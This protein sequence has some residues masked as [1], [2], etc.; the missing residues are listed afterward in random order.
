MC[1][2]TP[3]CA[4]DRCAGPHRWPRGGSNVNR[5]SSPARQI[6]AS[7]TLRVCASAMDTNDPRGSHSEP[8]GDRLRANGSRAARRPRPGARPRLAP[9]RPALPRGS[10]RR[11]GGE[12]A[13]RHAREPTR[14][15]RDLTGASRMKGHDV[16]PVGRDQWT[17][18]RVAAAPGQVHL[19]PRVGR[20]P[21]AGL[22]R[23]RGRGRP[24]ARSSAM[25]SSSRWSLGRM[26]LW[27]RRG[28]P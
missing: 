14:N 13:P 5:L 20:Q 26:Q 24:V 7:V 8:R 25:W 9:P 21:L 10:V 28:D 16:V 19:P 12:R 1:V 27:R 17:E 15:D 6:P 11:A 18:R 3:Q 22:V 4:A 2:T 23:G